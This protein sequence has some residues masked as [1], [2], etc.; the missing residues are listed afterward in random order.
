MKKIVCQEAAGTASGRA[1]LQ[2]PAIGAYH[3]NIHFP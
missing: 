3:V 1:A 2:N